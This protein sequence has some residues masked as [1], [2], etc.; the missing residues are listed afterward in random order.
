M[1]F[2]VGGGGS[3]SISGSS[4]VALSSPQ[5]AQIL[6]YDGAVQKWKNT[7]ANSNPWAYG[8]YPRVVWS[9]SAWPS[10]ASALPGG[11]TGPVEYW[12]ATDTAATSPT[13]RVVGDIWTRV[14]TV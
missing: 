3:Q 4:D 14:A 6:S 10:R 5:D 11:Y 12:S 13:D 9:G 7:Q 8:L 2:G 1:T